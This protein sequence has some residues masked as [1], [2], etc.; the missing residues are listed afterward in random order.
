MSQELLNFTWP[1]S[2]PGTNWNEQS[3]GSATTTAG[4]LCSNGADKLYCEA[5]GSW[6]SVVLQVF[7]PKLVAGVEV[8]AVPL[9]SEDLRSGRSSMSPAPT[10]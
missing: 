2:S 6:R 4:E 10:P 8:F 5:S 7:S 3:A 1:F 9:Y